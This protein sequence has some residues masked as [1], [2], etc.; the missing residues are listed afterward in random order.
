ML[1]FSFLSSWNNTLLQLLTNRAKHQWSLLVH[2]EGTAQLSTYFINYLFLPSLLQPVSSKGTLSIQLLD[3]NNPSS[4]DYAGS[5]CDCCGVFGWCPND[6]EN[7]FRII[8]TSY[9]YNFFSALSPWE[10]WETFVLGDDSF[11]FPGYGQTVGS[12]L[13]NPLMYH[14]TGRWPVW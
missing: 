10:R 9:P 6:C 3:Y 8:V 11:D 1:G 7:F 4:K 14:F 12:S 5:C 2:K 13:H